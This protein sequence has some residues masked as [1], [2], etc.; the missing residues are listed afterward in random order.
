M[1]RARVRMIGVAKEAA[2]TPEVALDL[3][4]GADVSALLDVLFEKYGEP[5]RNAILDPV[6]GTP[7]AT[8]ILIDGAEI[9]NL[10]GLETP[11]PD[12]AEVVILSVTH[13]G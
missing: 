5:L 10:R 4:L 13:G 11:V 7:V 6:T 12:G 3:P 2:G 9:G 8:L 1:P